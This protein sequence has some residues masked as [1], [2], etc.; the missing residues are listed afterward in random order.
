MRQARHIEQVVKQAHHLLNLATNDV[1]D[2][3]GYRM[4][5]VQPGED[6][7]CVPDRS[8]RVAQL[9]RQHGQAL[10]LSPA[11]DQRGIPE[12]LSFD[13]CKDQMPVGLSELAV[14]RLDG[15]TVFGLCLL[16]LRAHPSVVCPF[17]CDALALFD[18]LP[19]RACGICSNK[20]TC[21]N[22]HG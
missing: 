12:L 5:F 15:A 21:S 1:Q 18:R 17:T 4:R 10:V 14:L 9:M 19:V 11:S 8:E 3:S 16:F 7:H 20:G 13:R 6:L 22:S 2:P